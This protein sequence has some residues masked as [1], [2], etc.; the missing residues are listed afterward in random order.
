MNK[1]VQRTLKGLLW[2]VIVVGLLFA[3][4]VSV[5]AYPSPWF[6]YSAQAG[7]VT[8]YSNNHQGP[9]LELLARGVQSRAEATDIYD[10]DVKLRVYICDEQGLYNR[11]ARLALVPTQVP[12]FNLSIFNNSFVSASGLE[13]RRATNHARIEHSAL[14]GDLEQSIAHELVHDYV[15]ERIGFFAVRKVPSWKMEGYVEYQAS[16]AALSADGAA[17]LADRIQTMQSR[18]TH[19]RAREFYEWNLVVEYL[20]VERGYSFDQIMDDSVTLD[21]ARDQM[22]SWYGGSNRP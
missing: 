9:V 8:I 3:A 14:A 1:R 2:T 20:S 19:P 11:F 5:L 13:R 17:T 10:D 16:K 15:Q 21:V 7:N 12:G 18:L 4:Q 22:M 6:D